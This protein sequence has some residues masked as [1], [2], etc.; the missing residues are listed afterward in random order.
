MPVQINEVVIRAAID[1]QGS[2]GNAAQ[3]AAPAAIGNVTDVDI[4]EKVIEILKE[5]K[6]R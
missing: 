6:E 2:A 5:K 3:T 4:A 1:P